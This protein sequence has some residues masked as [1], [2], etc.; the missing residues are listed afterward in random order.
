LRKIE[1]PLFPPLASSRHV[2]IQRRPNVAALPALFRS[3]VF[4]LEYAW[5]LVTQRLSRVEQ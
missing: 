4:T 3:T 1:W 5:Y 2:R